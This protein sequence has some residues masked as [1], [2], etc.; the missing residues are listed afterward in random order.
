MGHF[1]KK[2]GTGPSPGGDCNSFATP[3][4]WFDILPMFT[5]AAE[6]TKDMKKHLVLLSAVL[7]VQAVAISVFAQQK[8]NAGD[9]ISGIVTDSVSPLMAVYITELD[10]A[11]RVVAYAYSDLKG[12]FSFR[13]VNPADRIHF[14]FYRKERIILPIDKAFFEIRMEDDKNL[15]PVSWEDLKPLGPGP[16]INEAPSILGDFPDTVKPVLPVRL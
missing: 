16:V 8:P 3:V 11:D 5:F 4:C 15:P 12:E 9:L 14:S 10:S 6:T 13:L 7:L 2:K 1:G